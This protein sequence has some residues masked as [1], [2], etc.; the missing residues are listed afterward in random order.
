M[1]FAVACKKF[2]GQKEGQT[3]TKFAEEIKQLTPEDRTEF[4]VMLSKEFGEEI[5]EI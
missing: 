4:K 5:V 3:L 2:F 1:T